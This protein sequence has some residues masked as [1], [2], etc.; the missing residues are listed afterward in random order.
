[1]DQHTCDKCECVIIGDLVRFEVKI[2]IISGYD[3]MEIREQDLQRDL[4]NDLDSIV[5]QLEDVSSDELEKSVYEEF[6]FDLCADCRKV[7][8]T[9]PLGKRGNS[10][11]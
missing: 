7:F 6:H 9:N 8:R 2:Q 1:M 4:C 10:V 3:I 11:R 5:K